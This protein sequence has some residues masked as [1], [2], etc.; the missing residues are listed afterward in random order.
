MNNAWPIDV[1]NKLQF[2]LDNMHN[3]FIVGRRFINESNLKLQAATEI[4]E[5]MKVRVD[6][7]WDRVRITKGYSIRMKFELTRIWAIFDNFN[8][9]KIRQGI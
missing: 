2:L 8:E 3:K 6:Y 1:L 7:L 9:S 5:K 4:M